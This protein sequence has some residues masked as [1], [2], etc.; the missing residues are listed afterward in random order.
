MTCLNDKLQINIKQLKTIFIEEINYI[1]DN[2]LYYIDEK[3]IDENRK[4]KLKNNIIK[5]IKNKINE[6]NFIY[7]IMDD[8]YCTFKHKRGKNDGKFCSKKINTNLEIGYKK[9]YLC[10]THSKKHIPKKRK[11]I[12]VPEVL[13]NKKTVEPVKIDIKEIILDKSKNNNIIHDNSFKTLKFANNIK[14]NLDPQKTTINN[15]L[16]LKNNIKRNNFNVL[17]TY[18]N[19]INLYKKR[20]YNDKGYISLIKE[21]NL[22]D[23]IINKNN[24]INYSFLNSPISFSNNYF[25]K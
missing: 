20:V 13:E 3:K 19:N 21:I 12:K 25:I 7:R 23:F 1:I 4:I 9:D 5:E 10:C 17:K 18:N 8:N 14:N 2:E 15:K 6:D 16:L 24:N 22:S 11:I